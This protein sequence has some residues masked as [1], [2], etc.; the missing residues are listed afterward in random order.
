MPPPILSSP[1]LNLST[2][3]S[4]ISSP[5]PQPP[6]T[7]IQLL[8]AKIHLLSDPPAAG[9]SSAGGVD[10]TADSQGKG[11]GRARISDAAQLEV[12]QCR[13]DLGRA[14]LGLD[15]PE[16]TSA[17]VELG[18]VEKDCK[19]MMKR[20]GRRKAEE[21]GEGDG[22]DG[23]GSL[24]EGALEKAGRLRVEALKEMVKVEEGLGREGRAERW[25]K[26]IAKAEV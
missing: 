6:H 15:V 25:R 18:L 3:N 2:I 20:L 22:E 10:A 5:A 17:E 9:P 21:T 1:L 4:L 12:L 11:K 24:G 8:S 7:R 19:G 14:Y 13:L 23:G 16:W 26:A